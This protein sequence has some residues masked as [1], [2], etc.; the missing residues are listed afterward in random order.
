M[1][2]SQN[3]WPAL[4][5]A[6]R[7]EQFLHT[8]VIPAKNGEFGLRLRNGS[9]GFLLAH[10]AL[11]LAEHV[12]DATLPG[13]PDDW[14]YAFRPV[15]GHSTT[16]SNHSSGTAMD[17][18]ATRHPLGRQGTWAGV[19]VRKIRGRL[20]WR[21]YNGCIRWGGDYHNR[22][23]EMHFEI[24]KDL[25]ACEKAARKLMYSTK[26]GKRILD[27]NPGQGGVILS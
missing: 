18:N 21:A 25:A 10:L 3:H 22:K 12:E 17:F 20:A 2:T 24:N 23:D 7:Q 1:S 11:Y 9:A 26:V 19:A 5:T 4:D 16:L 27:A 14:G 15:R 6:G 8:W 13:V